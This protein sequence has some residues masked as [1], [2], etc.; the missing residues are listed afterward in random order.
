MTTGVGGAQSSGTLSRSNVQQSARDMTLLL[1][2][3]ERNSLMA[4]ST[5]L[6]HMADCRSCTAAGTNACAATRVAS[7]A[8]T[9][10]RAHETN[11]NNSAEP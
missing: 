4:K 11:L 8:E 7:D 2:Q 6:L 5:S 3:A 1:Q 10:A 9:A